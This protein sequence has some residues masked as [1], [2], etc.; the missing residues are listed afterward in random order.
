MQ[1]TDI[2]GIVR[3]SSG[4]LINIDKAGLT[5]YKKQKQRALLVYQLEQRVSNLE[6]E[7]AEIKSLLFQLIRERNG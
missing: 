1:Q 3:D 2:P 7:I 6:Q 5:S 4:A